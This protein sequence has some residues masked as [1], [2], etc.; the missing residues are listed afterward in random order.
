MRDL[1]I[2]QEYLICAVNEKGKI[3]GF[4]TERLVCLVAAGLLDM[5][6]AGAVR[7]TEKWVE[8]AGPL[9]EDK[10]YLKSLY[11]FVKKHNPVET[12][13]ILEEYTYSMSDKRLQMLLDDVGESLAAQGLARLQEGGFFGRK[14]YVPQREAIR[15]VVDMVRAELLE[16]GPVSQEVLILAVLL[17]KG[18]ISKDYFSKFERQ[19]MAQR[20]R[21]IRKTREGQMV[22]QMVEY[23]ENM[24]AT[25]TVLM[26]MFS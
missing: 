24:I 8:I 22:D 7:L 4:S 12:E 1:S 6:L 10:E 20:F 26:T 2:T 17:D 13:K 11:L 18:K 25:M 19:E 21:A 16:D 23:I 5:E 15:S 9:P 14:A 3:S